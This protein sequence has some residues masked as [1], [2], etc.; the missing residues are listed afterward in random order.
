MNLFHEGNDGKSSHVARTVDGGAA[1]MT[2]V[3]MEGIEERCVDGSG[4]TQDGEHWS[5]KYAA[6]RESWLC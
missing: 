6:D 5:F 2:L 3:L 1:M 4:V